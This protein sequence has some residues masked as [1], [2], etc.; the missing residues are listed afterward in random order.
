MS[1]RTLHVTNGD[2]VLHTWKKAGLLGTHLAW[3]DMLHEGPVPAD[4][5]LETLSRIRADYLATRGLGNG[6]KLHH[7]FE[8]RDAVIRR[9]GEFE[10]IVLWFEHDLY[11]QLHLLQIVAVLQEQGIGAGGVQL[12]QSDQYLGLLSAEEMMALYPK[13]RF[14]TSAMA[15]AAEQAWRS[16]TGGSPHDLHATAQR[17]YA[18][19]PFLSPALKR[20]CEE[21]PATLSG[22][23][24]TQ[25]HVLE[26]CAQGARRK[27]DLFRRSQAREEASFLGDTGCYAHIDD[28][29]AEPAPLLSEL[30][31]GYEL[32]VLG[33]RVLAGDA[34]WLERQPLDRWIGGTHLTAQNDWRWDEAGERMVQGERAAPSER[35]PSDI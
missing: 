17:P 16:F 24:R 5:P 21:F 32:T 3:R 22:L 27:E 30:E 7:D 25:K 11:D 15:S 6:I 34:D 13:R 2:S 31:G 35:A 12:V 9:G 1:A 33:R 23:S 20:L 19:L 10:E 18:G 28:L 26:A 29:C 14:L 4:L 8:K